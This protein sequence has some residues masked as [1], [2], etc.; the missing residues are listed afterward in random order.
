MKIVIKVG[1]RAILA[2]DGGINMHSLSHLVAQIGELKKQQHAVILVS[3]GAVAQGRHLACKTLGAHYGKTAPE[4]QLL[5]SIGQH[6]L[7]HHY[8]QLFKHYGLLTAQ[9]LL[10][11]QDFQ[12]RE[13]Y[14]NIAQLLQ[15]MLN[16]PLIMPIANEN[17]SVTVNNIMFTDNDEL[18]GLLAAQINADKLI[19]L[20]S[21]QGVYDGDPQDPQAKIISIINPQDKW[22]SVSSVKTSEGR[23]GML[24][25]LNIARKLSDLG[26]TTHIAYVDEPSILTE[27]VNDKRIGTTVLP[28]KKKSNLKRRIAFN[29]MPNTGAIQINANLLKL[30]IAGDKVLSILPVGIQTIIGNFARG[31]LIDIVTP[32]HIKIGIGIARYSATELNNY[33]GQH[34]KPEIIHYD[35]LYLDSN[36]LGRI[37]TG[38]NSS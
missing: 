2:A 25:K 12:S 23:G 22:H 7:M 35:Q 15:A 19:L 9:L 29:F 3:S 36:Q 8:T 14:L 26:T 33:L 32:D 1:T 38:A 4:K 30:L 37:R 10:T 16:Q 17:D 6:E 20:T 24:S 31:D 5:A 18:A 34:N 21:V 11:T 13:H 27:L 28:F